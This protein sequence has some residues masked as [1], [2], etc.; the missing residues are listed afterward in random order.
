MMIHF[1]TGDILKSEAEC[2][3][4]TV[5]CEGY[6]GKG[7]AYQFKQTF[8]VNFHAY[9]LFCKNHLLKPGSLHYTREQNKLIINFPT[10]NKWREKSKIEYIKDGLD[11]LVKLI[12]ELDISSIAIPP[13]GCGNGGLNWNDVRPIILN[14]LEPISE[15]TEI[16]LYEPS[17]Y[18]SSV[19]LAPPKLN[20]SHLILMSLKPNLKQ[21]NKINIQKTAYFINLFSGLDY[22]KFSK[23]TYGP[24]SYVVDILI[25]DI[26]EYQTHFNITTEEAYDLAL[27]TNTSSSVDKKLNEFKPFIDMSLNLVNGFTT[28]KDLELA[29]T[30]CYLIQNHKEITRTEVLQGVHDWSDEKKEKFTEKNISSS[31]D[32]LLNLHVINERLTGHLEI[33][34]SVK[35]PGPA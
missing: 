28:S 22:F 8:P 19:S 27:K 11:E 16:L 33:N 12:K 18:Y 6:M 34:S 9:N 30:I 10:K 31:I 21:F 2:L 3:I 20:T 24:Y 32:V 14:S 23:Y 26:K 17:K 35:A 5:N 7:I 1:T 4:N 13:L 29:A 25:K 15:S